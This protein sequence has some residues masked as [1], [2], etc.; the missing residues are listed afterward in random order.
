MK[1][2]GKVD[3]KENSLFLPLIALLISV[4]VFFLSWKILIPSIVDNQAK[5]KAHNIDIGLAEAKI[6]SLTDA[7]KK[8]A[9]ISGL[10]NQLLVAIPED[11]DTPDLIAEIETIAALN[12]VILPSIS[13]PVGDN[14]SGDSANGLS[15][16]ISVSGGFTNI[17]NFI[18]SL[19]NSIR[20]LKIT[21]LSISSSDT[22]LL[23]AT[24][25]FDVY[26]RPNN[27]ADDLTDGV[28]YE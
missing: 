22:S 11:V 19:E 2:E 4:T 9:S 13:P 5:I 3:K 26:K 18:S 17:Y 1:M 16:T 7:K 10:V 6:Q 24:I 14:Q 23:N 25:T 20:F 15:A 27:D 21:S 12:Q 28:D 8:I